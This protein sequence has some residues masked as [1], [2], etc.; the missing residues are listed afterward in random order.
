M[1][2]NIPQAVL[3]KTLSEQIDG[4]RVRT[5]V[6]TTFSF[7]PGFFEQHVLPL[8]FDQSFH[9]S[10]N[11]RRVQLEDSLRQVDHLEIYY[12]AQAL[13]QDGQPPTLDY[14]RNAVR[15]TK[16]CFHPKLVLL[17]VDNQSR[18]DNESS[19]SLIFGVMSANLSRSGWWENLECAHFDEFNASADELYCTYRQDLLDLL[20]FLQ[21]DTGYPSEGI[22]LIREFIKANIN[23]WQPSRVSQSGIYHTSL[24]W[25]QSNLKFADWLAQFRFKKRHQWHLEVIAPF[26]DKSADALLEDI[27]SAVSPIETRIYTPLDQENTA[28]VTR[29][30]YEAIGDLNNIGYGRVKWSHLPGDIISRGRDEQANTIPPRYVHAKVYRLWSKARGEVLIMGSVN[31]TQPAHSRVGAGNVETA[32]LVHTSLAKPGWWLQ[33]DDAEQETF[34]EKDTSEDEHYDTVFA[35]IRLRF[36]WATQRADFCVQEGVS[37][38]AFLIKTLSGIEI[39]KVVKPKKGQWSPI[40]STGSKVMGEYLRSGAFFLIEHEKGS[41]KVLAEECNTPQKPSLLYQLSAEEILQYWSLLSAD[42]RAAFLDTRLIFNEPAMGGTDANEPLLDSSDSIFAEFA[43]IFHSFGCLKRAILEA[44]QEQ[45]FKDAETRLIGQKYDSMP[46]LLQKV[47]ESDMSPVN[48]YITFLTAQ[49]LYD[50]VIDSSKD[51]KEFIATRD[52]PLIELL[53]SIVELRQAL[54]EVHEHNQAFFEWYDRQFLDQALVEA[55]P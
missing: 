8:L 5:A 46:S 32:L 29:Q 14:T 27:L 20:K 1:A 45:R 10:E 52:K 28:T 37:N 11:L 54:G 38:E 51:F 50:Q 22:E 3:S 16:G 49:Q 17:L 26:I 43:G 2:A 48:R 4:R 6:F 15:R 24:Y 53:S 19:Q 18:Q 21:K 33:V 30:T 7:D 23:T 42:Q 41:W 31:F 47:L 55:A 13:S 35:D 36:D 40:N 9:Q 25:G 12:D 34:I 39:L 44:L